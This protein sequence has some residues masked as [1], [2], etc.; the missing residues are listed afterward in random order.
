MKWNF[1]RQQQVQWPKG[2]ALLSGG[3]DCGFESRL[4]LNFLSILWTEVLV[5]FIF[6]LFSE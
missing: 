2:K 3:S 5:Y 6:F 4:D 1:I